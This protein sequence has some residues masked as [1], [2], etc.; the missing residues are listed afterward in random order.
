MSKIKFMKAPDI[1]AG[2]LILYNMKLFYLSA[3]DLI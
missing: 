1:L 2:A 3:L